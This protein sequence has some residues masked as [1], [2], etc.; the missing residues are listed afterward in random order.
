MPDV[1]CVADTGDGMVLALGQG[2]VFQTKDGRIEND[3]FFTAGSLQMSLDKRYVLATS[4]ALGIALYRVEDGKREA[5][6]LLQEI[7]RDNPIST[8][9][10]PDSR[11]LLMLLAYPLDNCISLYPERDYLAGCQIELWK[12]KLPDLQEKEQIP[13][14]RSFVRIVTVPFRNGYLFETLEGELY[15]FDGKSFT[16]TSMSP[17]SQIRDSLVVDDKRECVLAR[18]RDGYKLYDRRLVE[19]DREVLIEEKEEDLPPIYPTISFL[20]EED[21][22]PAFRKVRYRFEEIESFAFLN[23]DLL[24]LCTADDYSAYTRIR[25]FS[26]PEI[27]EI[28]SLTLGISL[29]NVYT[30]GERFL[31]FSTEDRFYMMEVNHDGKGSLR[32][33]GVQDTGKEDCKTQG[34]SRRE[35][36]LQGPDPC[37]AQRFHE[38]RP[39]NP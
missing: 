35:G 24:V 28:D 8:A 21:G 29:P 18:Y 34:N 6:L 7:G 20:P 37:P 9:F 22:K 31:G 16:P 19:V 1:F 15:F 26:Y 5:L 23:P 17:L 11:Y 13:I 25:V 36:P 38:G 33:T 14:P 30:L 10:S 39:G 32:R 2:L 3:D 27:E 4:E 12:L